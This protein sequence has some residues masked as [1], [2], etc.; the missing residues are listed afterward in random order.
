MA[1]YKQAYHSSRALAAREAETANKAVAPAPGSYLTDGI[2]LFRV[3]QTL[4]DRIAGE[5][6][7]TLEDCHSLEIVLC[8]LRALTDRSI[9]SV[10]PAHA[11]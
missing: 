9:R 5:L 11:G 2:H 6:V 8:P 4:P 3:A 1:F 10:K 7:V